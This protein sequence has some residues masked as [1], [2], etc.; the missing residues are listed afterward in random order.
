MGGVLG[1]YLG[2]LL[3]LLHIMHPFLLVAVALTSA[4]FSAGGPVTQ[5]GYEPV[6]FRLL[7]VID[8]RS[9]TP[10]CNGHAELCN[11]SY[12]NITFA[13]CTSSLYIT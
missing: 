9:V 11:R 3:F 1:I 7:E 10:V 8:L 13:G 2:G 4:I 6:L 5:R 12:S